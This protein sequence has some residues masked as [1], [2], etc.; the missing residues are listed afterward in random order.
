MS[1]FA[2]RK[3]FS[4]CFQTQSFNRCSLLQSVKQTIII[5]LLSPCK[6]KL[7]HSFSRFISA[8][9]CEKFAELMRQE[10]NSKNFFQNLAFK[11]FF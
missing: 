1:V 2:L 5:S 6:A 8:T 10:A 9:S 4:G 3:Y 11:N 7:N